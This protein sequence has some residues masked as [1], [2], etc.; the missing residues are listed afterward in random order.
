MKLDEL[1]LIISETAKTNKIG[2][3]FMVGGVPRDR[4]I[5]IRGKKADI[6]DIDITT[7][8]KGSI[9]LAQL[10][11][12]R[13][14]GSHF[15][16]YDDGHSSL[17][18]MGVHFDFSSNFNVPNIDEE[19]NKAGIKDINTMK[20]ELYSRDF[21]MNTLLESLDFTAIY[22]ITGEA[23]GDIQSKLIKCPISANVTIGTDPRRILRAIKFAIKFDFKIDDELKAAIRTY[24][25]KIK[26]LPEKFVQDKAME[27][28]N[29]DPDKGIDYLIEYKILPLIPLTKS[30]SDILIQK[31]KIIRAL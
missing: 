5:G 4:I 24:R 28:V 14:P 3:P 20:R 21:T 15:M 17:D 30:L 7:G 12:K 19:L 9:T 27:I 31:R 10:L 8:D 16:T 11:Y 13:L 6:R 26:D 22:D 18:F 2:Q 23:I 1:L 29:L 25:D